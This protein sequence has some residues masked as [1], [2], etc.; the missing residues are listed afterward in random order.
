MSITPRVPSRQVSPNS[1]RVR[2]ES[3]AVLP[4]EG[5]PA[6]HPGRIALITGGAHGIGL[7]AARELLGC[8]L[9]RSAVSVANR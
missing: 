9:I 7:A 5:H 3:D 4:P 2:A 6:L 1:R 8:V